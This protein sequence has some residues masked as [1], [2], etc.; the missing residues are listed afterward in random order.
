MT[1]IE[2]LRI[3]ERLMITKNEILT[4]LTKPDDFILAIVEIRNNFV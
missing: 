2:R 4:A 1:L 3:Y